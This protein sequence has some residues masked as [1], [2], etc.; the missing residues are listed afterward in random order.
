LLT[1]AVCLLKPPLLVLQYGLLH[2]F[3]GVDFGLQIYLA[4]AFPFGGSTRLCFKLL[5]VTKVPLQFPL[6]M[7]IRLA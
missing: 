3:Y 5:I 4:A 6:Q 2:I 7:A 1:F